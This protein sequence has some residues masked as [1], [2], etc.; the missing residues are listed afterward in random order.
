M[1]VRKKPNVMS[2]NNLQQSVDHLG[3]D[4]P[5]PVLRSRPNIDEICVANSVGEQTRGAH[6]VVI[7]PRDNHEV[8]GRER[9][10]Q[11]VG[12]T[13]VIKV[14]GNQSSLENV[15]IHTIEIIFVANA[16]D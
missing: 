2:W 8:A 15:P 5:P 10:F 16:D 4:A 1:L 6:D 7:V 3:S 12:R 14:I 13:T 11:F 9:A